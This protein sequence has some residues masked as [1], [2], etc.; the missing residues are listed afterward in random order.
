MK[1]RNKDG[2]T[3][4]SLAAET[5]GVQALR[6]LVEARCELDLRTAGGKTTVDKARGVTEMQTRAV[7]W[8]LGREEGQGGWLRFSSTEALTLAYHRRRLAAQLRESGV[9]PALQ[10]Q[11]CGP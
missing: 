9:L 6:L 8:L 7:E 3:A 4:V 2:D 11:L 10:G 5:G 1:A